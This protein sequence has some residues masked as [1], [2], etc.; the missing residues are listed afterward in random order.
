[1]PKLIIQT[2]SLT[3]TECPLNGPVVIGRGAGADVP[4][5]DHRVSRRHAMVSCHAGEWCVQDLGSANGT[6]V[7]KRRIAER[8][9]LKNGDVVSIGPMSAMFRDEAVKLEE[10]PPLPQT[11]FRH[12]EHR[13]EQ[14]LLRM[15]AEPAESAAAGGG[16]AELMVRRLRFM[17]YLGSISD[18]VFDPK[19]LLSF[20]VEQ[21]FELVPRADRVFVMRWD[22]E[23]DKFELAAARDRSGAATHVS[24]SRTLLKEVV[25]KREA[26][27][28]SDA[29]TD[30]RYAHADSILAL[31]LRSAICAPIVFHDDV[32]GVIQIDST[33]GAMPFGKTEVALTLGLAS[34]VGLALGYAKI[35]A[36]MV[37]R[38]L[39]ERDLELARRIQKQFL[40]ASMPAVSGYGFAVHFQPALAIGGDFYDFVDLPQGRV[41]IVVG[42]VSGKGVSA[43]LYAARLTSELRHLAA[44]EVDA[45]TILA[46]ANRALARGNDESM[47]ATATLVVLE[48]SDGRLAVASAGHPL[49]I[50]VDRH[51]HVAMAGRAGDPPLGL[52]ERAAF[53]EEFFELDE[54]DAVLLY[55][56]GIVEA[57][58][59]KLDSFGDQRLHKAM[60]RSD[61]TP[62][63]ILR[64]VVEQVEAFAGSQPQSD[65]LTAV[66][67]R[68]R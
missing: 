51:G 4:V 39:L 3:G 18:L 40:P 50:V 27:L 5:E 30:K 46:R 8:V 26:V 68:R 54:D 2:G 66:C 22:R 15:G 7:N 63:G 17:E 58:N 57:V 47:F 59:I 45:A 23:T 48:P 65:D 43:A 41:A 34:Q 55:T 28:V 49:P 24:A 36:R 62:E 67:F 25:A 31:R 56:D 29:Q 16:D 53:H 61:R 37:E 38:E 9:R 6:R 20:V 14:V 60:I 32:F 44:G 19:A 64:T 11:A 10:T 13:D 42:D 52:D 12:G 1:M 33:L 35:H 21:L